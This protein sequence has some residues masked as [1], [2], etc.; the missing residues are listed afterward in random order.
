MINR[1]DTNGGA[2]LCRDGLPFTMPHDDDKNDGTT[3][4]MRGRFGRGQ[5]SLYI[6]HVSGF[7]STNSS[8]TF[9]S[10]LDINA[11]VPLHSF[12]SRPILYLLPSKEDF[13]VVYNSTSSLSTILSACSF[14]WICFAN[15]TL[16]TI[17]CK[18]WQRD[19]QKVS[20][21]H[22]TVW[23]YLQWGHADTGPIGVQDL[24]AW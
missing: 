13:T 12:I 17:C 22:K 19:A 8:A 21:T 7:L 16:P 23:I 9:V 18:S 6:I 15:V 5:L 2:R 4:T 3:I 20:T 24:I 14:E 1:A 10:A 11:L